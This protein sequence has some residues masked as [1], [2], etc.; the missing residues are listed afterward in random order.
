M[1]DKKIKAAEKFRDD[2]RIEMS[3]LSVPDEAN[4]ENKGGS[5]VF[6]ND[7][8]KK[9]IE[10]LE[11]SIKKLRDRAS[12]LS[13]LIKIGENLST[14]LFREKVEKVKELKLDISKI[15]SDTGEMN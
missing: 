11:E 3:E 6:D 9:M 2:K 1:N 8:V 7:Q 12:I 15:D 13:E 4:P 14:E 5:K 10:P